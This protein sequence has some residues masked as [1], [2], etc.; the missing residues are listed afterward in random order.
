MHY[1]TLTVLHHPHA[2]IK[3]SY[4][5]VPYRLTIL[6]SPFTHILPRPTSSYPFLH[7]PTQSHPSYTGFFSQPSYLI[8]HAT[9]PTLSPCPN[10]NPREREIRISVPP[11]LIQIQPLWHSHAALGGATPDA[12]P[13]LLRPPPTL[14]PTAILPHPTIISFCHPTLSYVGRGRMGKTG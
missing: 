7:Y 3:P 6:H 10:H 9:P 1:V 5:I 2:H 12:Y 4:L 14:Y 11:G 13:Y 8:R